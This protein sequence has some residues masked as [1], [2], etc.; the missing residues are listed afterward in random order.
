MRIVHRRHEAIC[1]LE[2]PADS[3]PGPRRQA[4]TATAQALPTTAA[5]TSL[6][7]G[8]IATRRPTAIAVPRS[9][10]LTIRR[11]LAR[12]RR[13][14]LIPHRA[15]TIQLRH[16]PIPRRAKAI[17]L[18]HDPT[19]HRA[20][21]IQLRRAPIPHRAKAMAVGAAATGAAEAAVTAAEVEVVEALVAGGGT[22]HI[23]DSRARPDVPG[24]P[25]PFGRDALA[26][27]LPLHLSL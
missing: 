20:A 1:R 16:A 2:S 7:N 23:A 26:F 8:H 15:A 6:R 14:R 3:P 25:F 22:N 17:L 10:A 12:T 24:G 19:P 9:R 5:L 4:T 11:P 21:A 18:H 27:L 13:R